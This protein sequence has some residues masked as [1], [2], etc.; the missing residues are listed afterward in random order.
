MARITLDRSKDLEKAL[1]SF[2]N[3]CKRE[4]IFQECKERRHYI[5]PSTKK[6]QTSIKNKKNIRFKINS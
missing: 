3:R 2:R 5:K 6:R 1:R 4:G